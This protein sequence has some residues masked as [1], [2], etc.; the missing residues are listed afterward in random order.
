MSGVGEQKDYAVKAFFTD[1]GKLQE[2]RMLSLRGISNTG[3]CQQT[4][5]L[6]WSKS[7]NNI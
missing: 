3:M 5:F 7:V 1:V 4:V 2:N 6:V